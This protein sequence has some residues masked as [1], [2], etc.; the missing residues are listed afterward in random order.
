MDILEKYEADRQQMVQQAPQ[1]AGSEYG[2][3][4]MAMRL[5]GGRIQNARQAS[6]IL[7]GFAVVC[8]L[9]AVLLFSFSGIPSSV[10]TESFKS[11]TRAR[12]TLP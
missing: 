2:F 7:L 4:Y 9:I 8:G 12:Q 6:F 10:D 11:E 1:V 5:S 3:L